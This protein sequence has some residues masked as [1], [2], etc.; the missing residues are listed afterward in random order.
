MKA[1]PRFVFWR[2][3]LTKCAHCGITSTDLLSEI[4]LQIRLAVNVL[5]S[6]TMIFWYT[7]QINIHPIVI[8]IDRPWA[9]NLTIL[10]QPFIHN[11]HYDDV[12]MTTM[13][14]QITSLAVVYS[15]VYSDADQRKHQSSASLAFVWG[16]HRDRWIPRT[17]D[18]LRGKCFHLMTSS[19][20]YYR[21]IV[22]GIVSML[23][24]NHTMSS[25]YPHYVNPS[26]PRLCKKLFISGL[27]GF[28]DR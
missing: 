9:D 16:I 14:S 25:Q 27:D 20:Y 19:C 21:I 8:W 28:L 4:V 10:P 7:I 17:K 5:L 26:R 24:I 2:G 13:A 22:I 12:I 18:Q 15:T 6:W 1:A 11:D 3:S 23:V